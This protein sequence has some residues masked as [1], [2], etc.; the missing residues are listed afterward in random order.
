MI[1][2]VWHQNFFWTA[3]Q[4]L[5]G[6]TLAGLIHT[7]NAYFGWQY[8]VLLLPALYLLFRSYQLYLGRL[9]QEKKHVAEVAE[10]HLRTIEALA[11]AIEAKDET[12]HSHLRRVQVYAVEIG[13]GAARPGSGGALA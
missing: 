1:W 11:L 10:L 6:A 9:E 4:Y 8:A 12:T 5:F 7:C 2:E 13:D 3:P